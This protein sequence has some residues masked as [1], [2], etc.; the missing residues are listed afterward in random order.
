MKKV[1]ALLLAMAL[2]FT[3]SACA[4]K[5]VNVSDLNT[6]LLKDSVEFAKPT[7]YASVLVL[8]INPQFELYLDLSNNVLAINPLNDDAKSFVNDIDL[9]DAKLGSIIEQIITLA[10]TKG[11]IKSDANTISFELSEVKNS[12]LKKDDILTSAKNA[13]NNTAAKLKITVIVN[14]SDK[15]QTETAQTSSKP[16]DNSSK[17]QATNTSSKNSTSSKPSNSHTHTYA[18]ATCKAP[19]TCTVCKA[20]VGSKGDHNYKNGKCTVCGAT[21]ALNPKTELKYDKEFAG[22]FRIVN[23][24]LEA[25]AVS[26]HND[27]ADGLYCLILSPSFEETTVGGIKFNNKYYQ[28]QGAG[29]TS[30]YLEVTNT[31]IIIKGRFTNFDG[32]SNTNIKLTLLSDGNLK[33]KSSNDERFP[34]N[35][36]L[37]TNWQSTIK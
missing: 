7:D 11:F 26:F 37:S 24:S 9:K 15:T 28:H 6:S 32:G 5:D 4:Q 22:N 33:V 25:S 20:T 17:T 35:T 30:H 27:E 14:T 23:N 3:L 34:V 36:M 29:M 12:E 16:S 19:K 8:S 21:K 2:V 1:V 18:N 10:N 31:E 13:A